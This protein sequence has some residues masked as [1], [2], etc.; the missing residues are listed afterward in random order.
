MAIGEIVYCMTVY[1][2]S[3]DLQDPGQDYDDVHSTIESLGASF[4]ALESTWFVDVT[5]M[6]AEM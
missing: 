5:N 2:V 1:A 4:H 6:S 3:Y